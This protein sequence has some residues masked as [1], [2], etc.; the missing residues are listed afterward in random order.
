[1]QL[2]YL[3]AE[4]E[5][6]AQQNAALAAALGD[7]LAGA[8]AASEAHTAEQQQQQHSRPQQQQQ[9]QGDEQQVSPAQ[10]RELGALL[11]RLTKENAALIKA[12][13][14]S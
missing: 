13:W 14:A 7:K 6:L 4:R 5:S 11:Q 12:R 3:G 2:A 1:V 9:Q 10:L 8:A